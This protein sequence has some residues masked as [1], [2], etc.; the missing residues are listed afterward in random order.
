MAK[1]NDKLKVK[2]VEMVEILSSQWTNS[3]LQAPRRSVRLCTGAQK[4]EASFLS[5]TTPVK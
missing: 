5:V 1:D 4:Q 3:S 2:M